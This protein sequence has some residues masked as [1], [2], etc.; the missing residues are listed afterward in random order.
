MID[1]INA[2]IRGVQ[3]GAI[4]ALVAVGLDITYA[5]TNIFNFAHGEMVMVGAVF[6][7]ILWTSFGVPVGLALLGAVVFAALLGAFTERFAVRPVAHLRE[8]AGW[9]L[10][11][12]GVAIIVRQSF[13]IAVTRR[14]GSSDTRAFNGFL[15]KPFDHVQHYGEILIN[16]TRVLPVVVLV[17]VL[18]ALFWFLRRTDAGRALGAVADDRDGALLRGLPV[19]KLS[20]LAF[21][22]GAAIA[23]LAGFVTG[24]ILQAS[25]TIGFGLTLKGFIAAT[26][27]GIPEIG[28]AAV[29]GIVLGLAEQYTVQYLDGRLQDPLIL[30]LLLLVLTLRPQGILGRRA[31]VV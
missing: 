5:T 8:S 17:I 16:P 15:P 6:G 7:V 19:N 30:V 14:P 13:E 21:A 22:M 27:G 26:I 20:M 23:A 28:G 10:A 29:G 24:P 18:V 4:Y 9:V 11:T 12:F 2:T 25:V 1:F 31:R 3:I